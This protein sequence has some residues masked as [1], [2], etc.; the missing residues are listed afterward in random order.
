MS[1][2]WSTVTFQQKVKPMSLSSFKLEMEFCGFATWNNQHV[3]KMYK[4]Y[5]DDLEQKKSK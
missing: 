3:E 2:S 1:L 4:I 5:I